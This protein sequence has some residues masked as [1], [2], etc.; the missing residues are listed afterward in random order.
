MKRDDI[1]SRIRA[2]RET[3]LE[4]VRENLGE[5]GEPLDSQELE[6]AGREL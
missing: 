5:D 2:L 6:R 1:E 3:A 4:R